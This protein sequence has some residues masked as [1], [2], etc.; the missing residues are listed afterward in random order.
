M[1]HANFSR[2]GGN[3]RISAGP[4]E[5]REFPP[6]CAEQKHSLTQIDNLHIDY[7]LIIVFYTLP[8]SGHFSDHFADH[9]ADH[10]ADHLADARANE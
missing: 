5:T 1:K 10:F 4:A 8:V 7:H 6:E 9:L 2:A 3:T